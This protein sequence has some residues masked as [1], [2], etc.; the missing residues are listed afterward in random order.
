VVP[1]ADSGPEEQQ[2]VAKLLP[3]LDVADRLWLGM[4]NVLRPT[5]FAMAGPVG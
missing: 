1:T 3:G 2:V 4:S 5:V